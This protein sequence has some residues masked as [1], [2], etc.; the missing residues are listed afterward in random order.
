MLNWSAPEVVLDPRR[1]PWWDALLDLDDPARLPQRSERRSSGL[2]AEYEQ[3]GNAPNAV[4]PCDF[5]HDEASGEPRLYDGG[6]DTSIGLATANLDE[7]L[8]AFP[9]DPGSSP[10]RAGAGR[11]A[12]RSRRAGPRPA[13]ASG[14]A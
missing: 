3:V 7:A 8:A 1:G 9:P 4:F 2:E 11:R 14:G 10:I 5:V 6:A 13:S 12:C